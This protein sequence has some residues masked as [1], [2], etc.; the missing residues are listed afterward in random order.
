VDTGVVPTASH[1]FQPLSDSALAVPKGI[2][3]RDMR[4]AMKSHLN[5]GRLDYAS[6]I[7]IV[8]SSKTDVDKNAC[9]YIAISVGFLAIGIKQPV[10]LRFSKI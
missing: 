6:L 2:F 3:D 4:V 7:G 1:S 8:I 5:P 10:S 9:F